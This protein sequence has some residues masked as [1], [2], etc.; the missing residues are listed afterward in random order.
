MLK[1]WVNSQNSMFKIRCMSCYVG[2]TT[3]HLIAHFKEHLNESKPV[4]KHMKSC[5][6]DVTMDDVTIFYLIQNQ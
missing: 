6:Y 5:N 2:Q 3:Q 1:K 4:D